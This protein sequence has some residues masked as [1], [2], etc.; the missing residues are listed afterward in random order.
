MPA[1]SLK[2]HFDG[3]SIQ[4]DE[5]YQLP[6]NAQLLVTILPNTVTDHE[7]MDWLALSAEG[8]ELAYG[9]NEPDYSAA[10]ILP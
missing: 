4:L 5:P 9:D 10:E 7:R 2:A 8:L 3:K 1:I 6:C